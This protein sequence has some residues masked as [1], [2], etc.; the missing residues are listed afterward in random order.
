MKVVLFQK[1]SI[2]AFAKITFSII[3]AQLFL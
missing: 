1:K 3:S 2:K